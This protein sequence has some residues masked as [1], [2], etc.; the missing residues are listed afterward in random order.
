[1]PVFLVRMERRNRTVLRMG[2]DALIAITCCAVG[3]V[4]LCQHR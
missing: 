4:V 3:L 1:M 2:L